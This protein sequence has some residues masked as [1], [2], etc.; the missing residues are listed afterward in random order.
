MP[1][2]AHV[3][4]AAY[5]YDGSYAGFLCCIFESYTRREIP[6]AVLGPTEGQITLF[7]TE[8]IATDPTHARR[9][10][11]GLTRLGPMVERARDDRLPLHRR[12]KGSDLAAVRPPL[13]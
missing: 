6:S 12:R 5:C 1:Y 13:L 3:S 9:V 11:N 10:A 4:D 7:G 8:A 2:P